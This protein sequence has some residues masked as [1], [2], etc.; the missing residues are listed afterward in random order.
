MKQRYIVLALLMLG[1]MSLAAGSALGA[2]GAYT[3]D[4]PAPEL[5]DTG[6]HVYYSIEGFGSS[7]N[8]YYPVLPT[9]T[10]H[11]EV[12]FAARD[13][14]V[15]VFPG[16]T[17]SLG[18]FDNYLMRQPPLLLGDPD[19]RPPARPAQMPDVTP[20]EFY[21]VN[22]VQLM[23]GHRLISVT[24]YPL[25]YDFASGEITYVSSYSINVSYSMPMT[26]EESMAIA[27]RERSRA[28]EPLAESIIENYG[29]FDGHLSA[30]PPAQLY[31]LA[32]PQYAIITT[33]TFES[34]AQ[35]LA[36]W[37][38]KKG[39]PTAVYLVSWIESN[40]SGYDTQEKIRNFLRLDSSTPRFDYVLLLGDTNTVPARLCWSQDGD[41]VPCDYYFSDVVD[42]SIGSG[43]DW[44]TDND[45]VW[46]EFDDT[47]TWLPDNYVGRMASRNATEV[48]T[49]VDAVIDYETNPPTGSWPTKAV[50]GAAFANY[51]EPGYDPTD[52]AAVAEH[53]RT[54]FLNPSG[55]TYDRLYEADGVS[56]TTYTYDYPL[57]ATNFETQVGYGCG[58]AF[59]SGHGNYQGNYRLIWSYDN[60]DG[61]YQ[62]GEGS[63]ADLCTQ[64]YNPSTGGER[65]FVL[66]GACLAGEFDRTSPCLGDFIIANWGMGAVASSRTSYYCIGWDDPDWPWN[67]GQEYRW[68]EEIFSNGKTH[69]GQIHGDN[70]YHY[71]MDFTSLY[72]GDYG[73]D[74]DYA[75]RKNMFS[76]NL[77]GD[78][79]L[80]VWT[81][82][83]TALAA[84]HDAT[85]PVGSSSFIVTVTSG[86][87][88]LSGATVC[89]WKGTEVYL[90]GTT[91]GSGE[92]TF[93][94]SPAT[95][96]TMYVTA[97]KHNYIPD[98]SSATVEEGGDTED[99]SV[100]VTSPNGG[101]NW[102]ID[103]FFDIMWNATDNVGVT[104]I[105]ILLSTDGGATFPTT[106]ASGEA[107]DG[108]YSW[109]VDVPPTTQARV[110]VIAYDAAANDGED[111]SDGNF[112]ISD[113]T[114]PVV[115]VTAPNGAE[116]WDAGSGHE[117]TWNAT[118]NIAVTSID[119]LLSTNGGATYPITIATG[120][121]NDGTYSWIVPDD[122]TTQARVKVIAHDAAANSGEDVSDAD[123]EIR[124]GT[125][126]SV[127]VTSPNGGENWA[128][129]SFFDITWNATDNVGVTSIDILLSTDGGATFPTTIAT[130]EANDG[131]Y[132]WQVDGPPTTQA[133]VK[134]VAHDAA[135]NSGE[136]VSD[137]NFD[138]LDGTD[139]VVTVTA[140]NGGEVWDI[141]SVHS[142]TWNATDNVGVT[143]IDIRL[144]T[145][146]GMTYPTVIAAGEDNDGTYSW[147]VP[148]TPTTE[149]RVKVIAHDG[150]GNTGEDVSDADFTIRDNTDPSVTVTS[151]NGGEV[152]DIGTLRSITWNATDNVGVTA[153][154]IRLSTDGGATYP[155]VVASGEPND[156]IYP[157]TVPASPTSTARIKVIAHDGEGNTGEDVSDANFE[158]A[159]GQDPQV[160]VI[161]PNGGET[162]DIGTFY[163]VRWSA[164]DDIG[165]THVTIVLSADGGA[166]YPDTL[167]ASEVND[168]VYSWEVTQAATTT[169]RIK[170]IAYDGSGNDGEDASNGDFEIYDPMAGNDIT[171]DIPSS[172]VIIGN[173]PN[174]FASTTD[175]RF[176][177]PRDGV[178]RMA[179]YDVNGRE[180]GTLVDQP[181]S[182]GY[183]AVTWRGAE[184]LGTGLYFVRMR[185]DAE[186]VNH[187][188][189]ISR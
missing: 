45:H 73:P 145:D 178:V 153:I 40:Y 89:L 130:G 58:F 132:S 107:N 22:S 146:G 131:V 169:A 110:K 186:E 167:S 105:D 103:S 53:V 7:T 49:Y 35:D 155:I 160:V 141:G 114:D 91:D 182:A 13:V 37:K 86:G 142:I 44:D 83:P 106:I 126:P 122:V 137:A 3:Y 164:T 15:T 159:D 181:F 32:N 123:F 27:M 17:Q 92:V 33:S 76:S 108:I 4:V 43:Y 96:G 21:R 98:E 9:R 39:V 87:G 90:V 139:P 166:T 150:E 26:E 60:G 152:W 81:D 8:P 11:Y 6:E 138:I 93:N 51:V 69:M 180:I 25:R 99:P 66:V 54:D 79:E 31:D 119:I 24:L 187:K 63:W 59:P 97:T 65:P 170:V 175:I 2:P 88:P 168:G 165:V 38:T 128:V 117:I 101:E 61:Y 19:Y 85:L 116:I 174:P 14:D 136:D 176:G 29:E 144:S 163:D 80:P 18:T 48:Q 113:G 133:R 129:D 74:M 71:A 134:V 188:V 172:A 72:S 78:P 115:T 94:P 112:E 148:A 171:S 184:S 161:D 183:H 189:V 5:R 140:P 67:Q 135:A 41:D 157:W 125:D 158:I 47:I 120:E 20:L 95:T 179:V 62:D 64:S 143:S 82:S 34:A 75:S 84:S 1:S 16:A 149:A 121:T 36:D 57:T 109:Q 162:C 50:F 23:R 46:G 185:F 56:P 102:A 127:T 30:E 100:T 156:G 177:I 42:G 68:W 28:L 77:F 151:P 12:P 104:S 124:D 147:T 111:V 55:V 118:D 154:D 52:M 10:V 70:K 173:S